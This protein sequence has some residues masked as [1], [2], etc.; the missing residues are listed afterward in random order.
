MIDYTVDNIHIRQNHEAREQPSYV[1]EVLIRKRG[2]LFPNVP[3][4]FHFT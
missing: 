3:I 4:H 1:S 2:G